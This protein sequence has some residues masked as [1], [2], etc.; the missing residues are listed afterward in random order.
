MSTQPGKD[1]RNTR[2]VTAGLSAI[3]ATAGVGGLAYGGHDMVRAMRARKK[4]PLKTKALVPLEVAGL[5]GEIMATKILHGD[6]KKPVAKAT[7]GQL[8]AM[9]RLSSSRDPQVAG[10]ARG[11]YQRHLE[12]TGRARP[13]PG[14]SEERIQA[15]RANEKYTRSIEREKGG[16]VTQRPKLRNMAPMSMSVSRE[17]YRVPGK[18]GSPHKQTL[19]QSIETM[20]T[21]PFGKSRETSMEFNGSSRTG[22]RIVEPSQTTANR[23]AREAISP[24]DMIAKAKVKDRGRRVGEATAAGAAAGAAAV[25]PVTGYAF[26]A[27][28]PLVPPHLRGHMARG[29]GAVHLKAG[30]ATGALTGAGALVAT[31]KHKTRPVAKADRKRKTR[32]KASA[33]RLATGGLFPGIHGLVAGKEGKGDHKIKAA[34]YELGGAVLGGTLVPGVGTIPGGV[35]GTHL[36]HNAGHYK[37]QKVGKAVAGR[38]IGMSG[39]KRRVLA[40]KGKLVHRD[41]AGLQDKALQREM[42]AARADHG[43]RVVGKGFARAFKNG[44]LVGRDASQSARLAGKTPDQAFHAATDPKNM[45]V[46]NVG[47][48][49]LERAQAKRDKI[50]KARRYDSEADRQRR[51]GY[52]GGAALGT[53]IVTGEVARRNSRGG[54]KMVSEVTTSG[55]RRPAGIAHLRMNRRGALAAVATGVLG[56]AAAGTFKRGVSERNRTWT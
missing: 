31:R 5:G 30:A 24:E 1:D 46:R 26:M 3:G 22:R 29:L 20:R 19:S 41:M 21:N 33:G 18:S 17:P 2:A 27:N 7:R 10:R 38:I 13:E 9:R 48:V 43:D 45:S 42:G 14:L 37:R 15:T 25:A 51:I 16:Y 4:I 34:G 52:V 44:V 56:A 39:L 54:I 28:A 36:A 11:L 53:G 49:K 55:K 8:I 23:E 12:R 40:Q 35:V 47:R 6:T 32:D 50:G